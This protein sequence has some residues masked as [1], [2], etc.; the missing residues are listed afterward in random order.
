[1]SR[2]RRL[3]EIPFRPD[4][5][6]RKSALERP[7]ALHVAHG[8]KKRTDHG[9]PAQR[10]EKRRAAFRAHGLRPVENSVPDTLAP[11]FAEEC[12]RQAAF[13]DAT[14]RADREFGQFDEAVAAKIA[15]QIDSLEAGQRE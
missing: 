15:E 3:T 12:A 6:T 11:G 5:T 13:S 1:M 14:N 2:G 10:V 4:A 9:S 7:N 8:F